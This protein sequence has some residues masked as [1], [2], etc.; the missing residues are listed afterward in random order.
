MLAKLAQEAAN[1]ESERQRK[2]QLEK[3]I[4][5]LKR[6]QLAMK[7]AEIKA[8]Q[9]EAQKYADQA[10]LN[11]RDGDYKNAQLNFKKLQN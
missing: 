8:R 9:Q 2:E 10:L 6:Q 3:Q 4:E 1:R 5:E 11:Y 7:E